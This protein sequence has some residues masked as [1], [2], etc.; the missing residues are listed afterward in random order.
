MRNHGRSPKQSDGIIV[1]AEPYLSTIFM[2][3]SHVDVS[4]AT[5]TD[6]PKLGL[7]KINDLGDVPNKSRQSPR[8]RTMRLREKIVV[9][10]VGEKPVD[11]P[12]P[13]RAAL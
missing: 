3:V 8:R 10:R 4:Y 5:M 1:K 13:L 11:N 9:D 2:R 12:L 7:D 6:F